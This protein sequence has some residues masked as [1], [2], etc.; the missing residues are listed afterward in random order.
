MI[1]FLFSENHVNDEL[2]RFSS[3]F[4]FISLKAA[5]NYCL[6]VPFPHLFLAWLRA[7]FR[8][9]TNSFYRSRYRLN[10]ARNRLGRW[11]GETSSHVNEYEI[12]IWFLIGQPPSDSDHSNGVIS[13]SEEISILQSRRHQRGMVR[14]GGRNK[15]WLQQS[16]REWII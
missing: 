14:I 2:Q 13:N 10:H 12:K 15:I 8:S 1:S 6:F 5:V 7:R 11:K 3:H 4:I 16:H 9:L